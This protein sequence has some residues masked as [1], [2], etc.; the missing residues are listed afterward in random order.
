MKQNNSEFNAL[1]QEWAILFARRSIHDFLRFAHE[2]N[3]SMPQINVLLR[4][5]YR[6]PATIASLREDL[7][8]SRAAATQLIDDLVRG[9]LVERVESEQDRRS[10]IVSLTPDGRVLVEQGIAARRQWLQDLAASFDSDQQ[11]KIRGV[12]SVMVAA[13]LK[14]ETDASEGGKPK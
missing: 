5:Y 9:G 11:A 1:L 2:R 7:Y 4:L 13:A 14:L 3:I 8:G 12:L 10:K 6:G